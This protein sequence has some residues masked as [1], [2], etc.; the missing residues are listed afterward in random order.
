[1]TKEAPRG[2]SSTPKILEEF[3]K[4]DTAKN[5]FLKDLWLVPLCNTVF[6]YSP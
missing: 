4:N 1:M 3:Q 6:E 2:V 5:L